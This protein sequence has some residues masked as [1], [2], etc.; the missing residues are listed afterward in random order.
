MSMVE[1][2]PGE[3]IAQVL[4]ESKRTVEAEVIN[5]SIVFGESKGKGAL[6]LLE[7]IACVRYFLNQ[8]TMEKH[9]GRE[10]GA[11]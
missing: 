4:E 10:Y 5:L 9:Y 6:I 2:L 1:P 7:F 3:G 11:H 8:R